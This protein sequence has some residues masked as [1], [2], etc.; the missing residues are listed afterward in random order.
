LR[1]ERGRFA[2]VVSVD[3]ARWS[4]EERGATGVLRIYSNDPSEPEK[5][6]PLSAFGKQLRARK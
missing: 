5:E 6:V 1:E 3:E 4:G 2:A